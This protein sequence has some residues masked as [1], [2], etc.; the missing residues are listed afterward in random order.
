MF[1]LLVFVV[2]PTMTVQEHSGNEKSCVWHATDFADGELKDELFCIRFG[3]IESMFLNN[4]FGFMYEDCMSFS[5]IKLC[6]FVDLDIVLGDANEY[7]IFLG[8]QCNR[9]I[10][11]YFVG[12]IWMTFDFTCVVSGKV[13]RGN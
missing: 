10:V 4:K 6:V 11:N 7:L 2:V 13:R 9:R 8:N 5:L 3:S 12:N 1:V